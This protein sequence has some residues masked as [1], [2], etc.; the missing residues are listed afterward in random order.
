MVCVG[1]LTMPNKHGSQHIFKTYVDWCQN[2]NVNV[3]PIPYDTKEHDKYFKMVNGLLIPG[4]VN[5]DTTL[6]KNKIYLNCVRTFVLL[7]LRDY[8]PIWGTCFGLQLLVCFIGGCKKLNMHHANGMYPIK[9]FKSR[10]FTHFTSRNIHT[11]EHSKSTYH[12]HTFGVSFD[13]FKNVHI[14]RFYN[15]S[16]TA[17][18]DNNKEYVAAI[19]AKYYPIYGTQFHPERYDSGPFIDF[20]I[21]EL[22]KNKHLCKNGPIHDYK[23]INKCI[24]E[25]KKDDCYFF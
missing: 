1:I 11:L 10:M 16:A 19:E 23:Y 7:S 18:D 15:I 8:F 4:G 20:F 12:N 22:K 5:G 6:L 9:T 24:H 25:N 2:N 21:S 17:I 14:R 3:V 13:N